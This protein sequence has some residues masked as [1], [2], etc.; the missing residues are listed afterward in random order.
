MSKEKDTM[1][2]TASVSM[3]ID[4]FN[5]QIDAARDKE[6][7]ICAACLSEEGEIFRGHR[8]SDCFAAM[9]LRA[10]KP[11]KHES[12]GFITSRGRYVNREEGFKLQLA[13]G[14]TSANPGGWVRKGELYSEDLY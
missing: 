11:D 5:Q 6:F 7:C 8:H 2:K 14:K 4:Q 9:H 1:E 10:K 12:Q 3:T 13:A